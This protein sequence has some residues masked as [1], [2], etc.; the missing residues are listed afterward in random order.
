MLALVAFGVGHE[1]FGVGAAIAILPVS[2]I[3]I[4][5]ALVLL[6][7]TLGIELGLIGLGGGR[8]VLKGAVL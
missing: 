7:R 6:V 3:E 1:A 5:A 4:G 8:L 2:A